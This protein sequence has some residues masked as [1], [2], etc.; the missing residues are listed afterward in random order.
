VIG[1]HWA[2]IPFHPPSLGT[3]FGPLVLLAGA[4]ALYSRGRVGAMGR[5]T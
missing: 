2:E 3:L 4:A 5:A 1:P